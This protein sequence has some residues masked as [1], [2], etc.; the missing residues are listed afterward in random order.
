MF[1]IHHLGAEFLVGF[2]DCYMGFNVR[3]FSLIIFFHFIEMHLLNTGLKA[4]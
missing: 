1:H 3:V 2:V 4:K